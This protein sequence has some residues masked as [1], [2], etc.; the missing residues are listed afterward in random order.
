MKLTSA[1]TAPADP[2]TR[3][4]VNPQPAP[5]AASTDGGSSDTL[6]IVALI[7]GALGLVV[8]GVAVAM[9]RGSRSAVR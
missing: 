9:A 3:R 2:G 5:A 7:V 8:A 1:T 6:S 4:Q